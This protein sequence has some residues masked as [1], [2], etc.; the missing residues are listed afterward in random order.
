MTQ[1]LIII[2]IAAFLVSGVLFSKQQNMRKALL[3][4]DNRNMNE[5]DGESEME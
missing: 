1:E 2:A 3:S 4:K 5:F